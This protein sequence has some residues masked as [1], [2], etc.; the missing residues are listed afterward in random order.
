MKYLPLL[1][2]LGLFLKIERVS[3][4]NIILKENTS[5]RAELTS[6]TVHHFT[7]QNSLSEINTLQVA[8]PSGVFTELIIPGYYFTQ[9]PGYP[10]VPVLR[11]LIEV[12][13]GADVTIEIQSG[14]YKEFTLNELGLSE[15]I[16]AQPPQ[17][18]DEKGN[19]R[20]YYDTLAYQQDKLYPAQIAGVDILG[21][22]RGL[23]LGR[24]HLSPVQYNPVTKVIRIYDELTI[25]VVF[26][27]PDIQKTREQKNKNR[28][29]YFKNLSHTVI[30][31][32]AVEKPMD[33]LVQYPV[34]YVIV[35]HP[36]FQ[37]TLQA[38]VQWKKKK[39]FMVIEAYTNNPLVG[40]TTTSIKNYLQQLYD[41]SSPS[42]PPPS[43]ILLVGDIAQLPTF[44]G[45]TDTHPTDFFYSDFTGDNLPD[46]Y[47]GRFSA[48]TTAQLAVEINKTLQYEQY[49]MPDPSFLDD[50]VMIAGVDATYA[51]TY[52]NGQINYGTALYYNLAHGLNS[53]TY[54]YPGSG[55]QDAQIIQDVCN[56]CCYANYTAHGSSSGWADP[57]FTTANIP[58]LTNLNKY[59]L[60]VGN[61]CLTNKFDVA[62]CFGEALIRAEGKGA[63]GY[64]GASN[65]TYWDEDFWWAVGAKPVSVNP[66]YSVTALGAYD[67][68]F[69]DHG[70][71]FSEWFMTQGQ[72]IFAGNLAVTQGSPASANYYWE[73]YH[74]MGDPSLMVYYSQPPPLPVS[75]NS[76]IPPGTSTF[77]VTT[78]PYAYAALSTGGILKGAAQANA[79]GIAVIQIDPFTQAGTADLVVTAQN[80]QPYIS[81]VTVNV[82]ATPLCIYAGNVVHDAYGNN[83]GQVDFGEE[84]VLD[85]SV[86]N[87][88]LMDADSVTVSMQTSD[89]YITLT[90]ST[91]HV[92]S[93]PS[94]TL[95]TLLNAFSLTVDTALP[96]GHS[97]LFSITISCDS[98]SWISYFSLMGHAPELRMLSHSVSDPAGNH[99][100]KLDIG[101]TAHLLINIKNTGSCPSLSSTA[102]LSTTSNYISLA[103]PV[104]ILPL[105][106]VGLT[107]Q[108]TFTITA[109]SVTP[110]GTPAIFTLI[111]TADNGISDTNVFI[112]MIG[113][114][115]A[116]II[117][118]DGNNNSAQYIQNAIQANNVSVTSVTA[119]PANLNLFSSI[120]L[121][122][123]IRNYNHILTQPEGAALAVYLNNGGSLY[124]EGGD[125]WYYNMATAVH[126]MF[127][128][129][130]VHNGYADLDT[131]NGQNGTLTQGFQFSYSGD[132][133]LIDRIIPTSGSS[134]FS[135]FK[136]TSPVYST[137]IAYDGGS[138]KTIGA[139]HEFGGL[140]DA[141]PPST[142]N[143]LMK[144][145]L[146]FFGIL[147]SQAMASFSASPTALSQGNTVSFNDTSVGSPFT[148]NWRF[149]GGIPSASALQNPS[150]IY[151]N[152]G[153]YPVSLS[154]TNP[155]GV[156][157]L[158]KNNYIEV[159][160]CNYPTVSLGNYTGCLSTFSLPVLVHNL[161]NVASISL[162]LDFEPSQLS[163]VNYTGVSSLLDD[164][165]VLINQN[166]GTIFFSWMSLFPIS[167]ISDTLFNLTFLPL[168]AGTFSLTWDTIVTGNCEITDYQGDVLSSGFFNG[169]VS[170]LPDGAPVTV[171][172]SAF[173]ATE[174]CSG[175]EVVF[176]A[177]GTNYG[178]TP[179]YQWKINGVPAAGGP[180]LITSA[181]NNNDHISCQLFSS[182]GC[183]SGS[184]SLSNTLV[185]SVEPNPVIDLGNDTVI[186]YGQTLTLT[187]GNGYAD[188]FWSTGDTT[189]SL[190]PTVS[191]MNFVTVTTSAGC[192][193]IDSIQVTIISYNSITG[194]LS[195]SNAS[196]SPLGG[197][198]LQLKNGS[199][200]ISHTLSGS[201][202]SFIFSPVDPG[203][204]QVFTYSS[205]PWGG[206][207]STDALLTMKHFVGMS[208]LTGLY[209]KAADVDNS[210]VIN[211]LDALLI[212]KRSVG[213]I[214]SF[215]AGNWVFTRPNVTF[216]GL[217]ATS[218]TVKGLCV[219]DV[220]GSYTPA[221][222]GK[223]HENTILK[224]ANKINEDGTVDIFIELTESQHLMISITDQLG[225]LIQVICEQD[226]PAGNIHLT[227][228]GKNTNGDFIGE[229]IYSLRIITDKDNIT[230]P[231][232]KTN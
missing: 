74:L 7:L 15:I 71:D 214:N 130:G 147:P 58:S 86:N 128:I 125:T 224:G 78:A 57:T 134:A 5:T 30:N 148:W 182:A 38:F 163:Y 56:G 110:P 8:T 185:M 160:S 151:N 107:I 179:E 106:P 140:T 81:T 10:K 12:P 218:V 154:I 157:T 156:D 167:I 178:L 108:D 212:Q 80:F 197:D 211:A 189:P 72:M 55:S 53:H 131:L 100:N 105:I 99:N 103:D 48:V 158:I 208:H 187:P 188:Y 193:A 112:I 173:P 40:S 190:T 129:T 9:Q 96:D 169:Q 25:R 4:G 45:V 210:S 161:V 231:L 68:T 114:E 113:Q 13:A 119:F 198:L 43:F 127:K 142:K 116:V 166:A 115:P 181:L 44:S 186:P 117:N 18:K 50:C 137:A 93:I 205:K 67:R 180:V 232:I 230:M 95:V 118:L 199:V 222:K 153:N 204:Y 209:Q 63:L 206:V 101:E 85:L 84:I 60:M 225:R 215:P 149:P 144:R 65:N 21:Y 11:R 82:P 124:M 64:I 17:I 69:H 155:Y 139:S 39:G 192:S 164:G 120:F 98:Q 138:Y 42:D 201:D 141:L 49:T 159:S 6:N 41:S 223:D 228:N 177:Y 172:I 146:E 121:C 77:T 34:K 32:I 62:E 175:T 83:N 89:P 217:E 70:E 37:S 66:V 59:P 203:D 75:F 104:I 111:V 220:N 28:G 109:S 145:Y 97:F 54:L 94:G 123:G 183:A 51:P 16:P 227:W 22:T 61:A 221:S 207:N 27:H 176:T 2:F 76:P 35:S 152:P 195:Y 92:D 170:I 171:L 184:P 3:C 88:G 196:N 91:E 1:I 46:V 194:S 122:L 226:I 135:I 20:F 19:T 132:N 24:L 31:D 33:T 213:Y 174:V 136:N 73:I 126:P 168:S 219:G 165:M 191:G 87:F 150:V 90:D 229:G 162:C 133:N 202:G 143:V 29:P 79:S 23:R 36:M 102:S 216:T 200:I 47:Y 26:L 14:H 52:A